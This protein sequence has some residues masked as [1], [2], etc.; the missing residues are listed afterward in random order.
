MSVQA[1]ALETL[2]NPLA[3]TAETPAGWC[4][5]SGPW[6]TWSSGSSAG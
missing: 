3:R 4:C 2:R 6:P 1:V 5:C